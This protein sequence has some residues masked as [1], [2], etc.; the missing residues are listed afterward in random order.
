MHERGLSQVGLQVPETQLGRQ[1][2]RG[3]I[4]GETAEERRRL[5]ERKSRRVVATFHRWLLAQRKR[6]PPGS[7]ASG[8]LRRIA[9]ALLVALRLS[10]LT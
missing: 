6:V 9:T 1:R 2:E 3:G 7:D 8:Y 4:E 5:R 10:T